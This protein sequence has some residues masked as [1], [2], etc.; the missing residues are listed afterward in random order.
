MVKDPSIHLG[1]EPHIP[2]RKK[3]WTNKNFSPELCDKLNDEYFF[4]KY[5]NPLD[6]PP[7]FHSKLTDYGERPYWSPDGKKVAFIDH[8]Y[9]D[10]CEIDM[11]T[12]EIRNL[13]KDLGEYHSF[14]RVLYLPNNDYIL[15]G[16]KVFKD[17]YVS[18][19]VENELWWM[20]KDAKNPPRPLGLR[21]FEGIGVSK[22]ANRI[23]YAING[24]QYPE[25]GAP[26]AYECHI[27]EIEYGPDGPYLGKDKVFYRTFGGFGP[28]PQDFLAND[29]Q[30]L[31]AEYYDYLPDVAPENWYTSTKIVDTLTGNVKLI[32][33]ENGV[34][35]ECE[36]IFPDEQ[37]CCLESF[38][39]SEPELR[40]KDMYM[41]KLDGSG[42]LIPLT[43]LPMP[44]SARNSNVSPDGKTLVFMMSNPHTDGG[45]L[46][47][48]LLDLEAWW[49]SD[50][51]KK[52]Q[53]AIP[54]KDFD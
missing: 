34:H 50:E 38:K 2:Y 13:T 11:E 37:Y 21:I 24:E 14:W 23:T 22:I 54:W 33:R 10:V 12:R 45:G 19:R 17:T 42:D 25:I 4:S 47:L 28:E 31:L 53:K 39:S 30:V 5:P 46:G 32:I 36:G 51:S 15:I 18:R 6:N 29:T 41:V 52:W 26:D 35:N 27:T 44:W 48:G 40:N 20:D 3:V 1:R 16:P 9:G 7:P 49:N 8:R 43:R